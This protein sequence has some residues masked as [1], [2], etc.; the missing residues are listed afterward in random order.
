MM[1][2][3]H[4]VCGA[5]LYLAAQPAMNAIGVVPTEPTTLAVGII[6]AAGA[7]LL[8][9]LD[10][11]HATVT[12]SLGIVTKVLTSF[13]T[14][15]AGGHRNGTHS[16]IGVACFT[17]FSILMALHPISSAI[18][19]GLLLAMGLASLRIAYKKVTWHHTLTVM[20]AV[21]AIVTATTIDIPI[22]L[23]VIPV[24]TAVGVIAHLIGDMMTKEGC[25]LLYPF[26]K[27]RFRFLG[28]TTGGAWET[29]V[30]WVLVLV[31]VLLCGWQAG[32]LPAMGKLDWAWL[33]ELLR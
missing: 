19:A 8:P 26:S 6:A 29:V 20:A 18:Y 24:A 12:H 13:I 32:V 9:D 22:S 15:L 28:L 10:S 33:I 14:K 3:T 1:G 7:A 4:A 16:L 31:I 30:T 23:S 21:I 27:K 11:P 5:A 25:P 2:R 17:A